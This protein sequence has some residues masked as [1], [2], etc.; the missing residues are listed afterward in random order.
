MSCVLDRV[1]EFG[2]GANTATMRAFVMASVDHVGFL[3][4]PIPQPGPN[5]AVVQ[6]LD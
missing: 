2:A 6:V 3:V 1:V 5:D 4:K